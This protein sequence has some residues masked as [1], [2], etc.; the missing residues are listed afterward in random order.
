MIKHIP[1]T[2]KEIGHSFLDT[3]KTRVKMINKAIKDMAK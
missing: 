3:L 2:T 1:K